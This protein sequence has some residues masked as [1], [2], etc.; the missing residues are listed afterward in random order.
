V[1]VKAARQQSVLALH[2]MGKAA[3][4]R[5]GSPGRNILLP[6]FEPLAEEEGGAANIDGASPGTW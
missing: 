1:P 6:I 3:A 4:H 5:A 2:R